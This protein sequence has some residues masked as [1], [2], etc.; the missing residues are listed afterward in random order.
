MLKKRSHL[1]QRQRRVTDGQQ[2][3]R[4]ANALPLQPTQHR[5]QQQQVH[6]PHRQ[7]AQF[8]GG[9]SFQCVDQR[10]RDIQ[11]RAK[12]NAPGQRIA[13]LRQ[14]RKQPWETLPL[15]LA[16]IIAFGIF[17]RIGQVFVAVV[18]NMR[19]A[20]QTIGIPDRQRQQA[21]QLID[22]RPAR[23]MAVD[24]FMLQR[25]IP[26]GQQ[27]QQR[28]AKPRPQRL[29]VLRHAKPAAVDRS[30]DAPGRQ[31]QPPVPAPVK[32]PDPAALGRMQ[33]VAVALG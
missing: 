25:H 7:R 23:W 22:S 28:C 29:P 17:M 31:L 10:S 11:R 21:K 24:K 14:Q 27:D 1:G 16:E 3:E 33:I 5:H 18:L 32:L 2:V 20:I 6:Q 13:Y 4:R 15:G 19:I 26:G 30:H 9:D 8:A 12:R